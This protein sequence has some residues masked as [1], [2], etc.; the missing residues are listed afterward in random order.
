MDQKKRR[1]GKESQSPRTSH[2]RYPG[3]ADDLDASIGLRQ[4]GGKANAGS[5]QQIASA[6]NIQDPAKYRL[7][8]RHVGH[9]AQRIHELQE[10]DSQLKDLRQ[11]CSEERDASTAAFLTGCLK[12]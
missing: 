10:L 7:L 12:R 4:G 3:G 9:V 2:H 5:G 8:D 11:L 1:Q 6:R